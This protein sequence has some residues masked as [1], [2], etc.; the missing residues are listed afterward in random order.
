[1]KSLERNLSS[2]LRM[3]ADTDIQN[4]FSFAC[5]ASLIDIPVISERKMESFLCDI[6][7]RSLAS[8]CLDSALADPFV[9]ERFQVFP[10]LLA[11][12]SVKNRLL[13][14][15]I[16]M[17]LITSSFRLLPLLLRHNQSIPTLQHSFLGH[18]C[19]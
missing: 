15:N 1:M 18:H 12:N 9:Q 14:T 4:G 8:S 11:V 17:A 3:G 6:P 2:S 5:P 19:N 7:V 10:G 13:R 16:T